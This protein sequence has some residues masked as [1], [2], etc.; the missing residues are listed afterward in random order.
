MRPYF[1]AA[2]L[3]VGVCILALAALRMDDAAYDRREAPDFTATT[4]N[5]DTVKLADLRG[6]V[7]VLDFWATWCG[8]CVAQIPHVKTMVRKFEGK[9]FVFLGVSVDDEQDVLRSFVKN[10]RLS[11]PIVFDGGQS[12]PIATE[13]KVRA[14]PTVYVIDAQG[15]IRFRNRFGS[16]LETAVETLLA[17]A[18]G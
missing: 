16:D 5:G 10:Q 9:P 2:L 13:Y 11:W 15:K 1:V 18:K 8:P 6:K 17:E 7:V 4:L 3:S 12:G 14:Y